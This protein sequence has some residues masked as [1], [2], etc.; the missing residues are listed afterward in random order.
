VTDD[1][2]NNSRFFDLSSG[3]SIRMRRV[4]ESGL[5]AR[6]LTFA[7]FGALRAL[8]AHNGIS[9]AELASALDTDSTTA[10]VLRTSLEKKGLVSRTS[11]PGD[12]RIKRIAITDNGRSILKASEPGVYAFFAKTQGIASEADVK[13][14]IQTLEKFYAFAGEAVEAIASA[15]AAPSNDS[16]R[17]GRAAGSA[18]EAAAM[19]AEKKRVV[20]KTVKTAKTAKKADEKKTPAKRVEVAKA[21]A[22][23]K[24]PAKKARKS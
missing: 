12:G 1:S 19:R 18:K 7:Q 20:A 23:K 13:K 17:G 24:A 14:A 16:K 21:K 6:G 8:S 10:M 11:D 3:V 5:R 2:A 15:K 22:A 4:I 9:Q